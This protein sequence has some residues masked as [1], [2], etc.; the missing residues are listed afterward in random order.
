MRFLVSGTAL[1]AATYG[2]ARFGYGLF[3]PAFAEAFDLSATFAGAIGAGSFAAYC[4]GA[5]LAYRIAR[6]PRWTVVLAGAFAA[7]GSAGVAVSGSAGALGAS[8]IGAGA[9]AGFASPGLVT[10]VEHNVSAARRDRAQATVNAG[11]GLGVM[12]AG[13]LALLSGEHWRTAW[14][15]I[16]V[17]SLMATAATLLTSRPGP[18]RDDTAGR[19]DRPTSAACRSFGLRHLTAPIVAA[20]LVGVAS[21]AVWTFGRS[22]VSTSGQLDAGEATMFWTVLGASGVAGALS[23]DLVVQWGVRAGWSVT[24]LAV[25]FATAALG[26]FPSVTLVAYLAAALFGASYV[27]MSGVLIAWAS[28]AAPGQAATGTAVLFIAL[29]AGQSGGAVL[30]GALLETMAA[31]YVF[32][33]AAVIAAVSLVPARRGTR[34]D[35]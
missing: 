2:L 25:G 10:L 22:L 30:F 20:L 13:L 26:A 11:T 19:D 18:G 3:L 23:G 12:V 17:L 4:V 28:R 6:S 16:V 34:R 14:W 1:I 33:V 35:G 9:G 15:T 29:A 27:A 31:G 24:A 21:A 7:G 5:A 32:L 8:V